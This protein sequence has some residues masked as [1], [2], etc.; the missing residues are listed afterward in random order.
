MYTTGWHSLIPAD[1]FNSSFWR[2]RERETDRQTD[3]ESGRER[4]KLAFR[5]EEPFQAWV[6]V[7]C[8]ETL[9]LCPFSLFMTRLGN[10][11]LYG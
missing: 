6:V 10:A 8:D 9:T 3:R 11:S 4:E 7:V 2:E 5:F 1:S